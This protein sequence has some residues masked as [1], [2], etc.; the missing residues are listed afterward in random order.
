MQNMTIGAIGEMVLSLMPAP[1]SKVI[2]ELAPYAHPE[3]VRRAIEDMIQE[4]RL[5][6]SASGCLRYAPVER[7]RVLEQVLGQEGVER[8]E[9]LAAV[10]CEH[11]QGQGTACVSCFAYGVLNG[12][13][14]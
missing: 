2:E 9:R 7:R 4:G 14:N 13:Q 3:N 5:I 6:E 8:L 11:G 10:P 12:M 1:R